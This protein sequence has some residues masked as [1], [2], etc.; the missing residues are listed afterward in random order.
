[1]QS[2]FNAKARSR[3]DAKE[4][5]QNGFQTNAHHL[6]IR[7]GESNFFFAPSRPRALALKSSSLTSKRFLAL[8][9]RYLRFGMVGASGIAVDMLA[10]FLLADPK[11]L[12]WDL[13]LSK[14]IAAEIA[15][16]SN[17]IGN[18]LWTFGDLS[19]ADVSWRGRA[20]R[21]G[22]FNLICLAGICL[23]IL[24]LNLQTRSFHI[25]MYAGNLISIL[26]VSLWNF[27]MNLRFGW[28]S[29]PMPAGPEQA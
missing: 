11:M 3:K 1:M 8:L 22:R 4:D 13:S 28:Q 20:A 25:N 17:F 10:L 24:L 16:F 21:F 23:S 18:E 9:R 27:A 26:I 12:A 14:A 15:I 2:E 6:V 29:S 7:I 5:G 19:K